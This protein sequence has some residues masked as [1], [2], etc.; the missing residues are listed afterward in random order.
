[1]RAK[2][3]VTKKIQTMWQWY[4]HLFTEMP[5]WS[6]RIEFWAAWWYRHPLY[7]IFFKIWIFQRLIS[8]IQGH[9]S[10]ANVSKNEAQML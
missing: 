6:T 1:M 7:W 5:Q 4:F 2:F 10:D 9:S 3:G 8:A